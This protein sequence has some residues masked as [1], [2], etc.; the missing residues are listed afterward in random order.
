MAS[1]D[2]ELISEVRAFT[3]YNSAVISDSDFQD[4]VSLGKE[5]LKEELGNDANFPGFFNGNLHVDRALFWFVVIAAKVKVGEISGIDIRSG[6]FLDTD[7]EPDGNAL[8]F[9][10]YRKRVASYNRRSG[11]SHTTVDRT[12]R[13]YGYEERTS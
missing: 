9:Q 4:L 2:S 13:S 8:L 7:Q 11:A 3:D 5:E 12:D 10:N 6:E 1:T